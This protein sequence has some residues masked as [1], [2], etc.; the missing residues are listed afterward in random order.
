VKKLILK[1]P[2]NR[3][4]SP[5]TGW[6]RQHWEETFYALMKGIVD[7][8]SPA[9]ARQRIPGPRSH[10][11]LLADELEGFTRSLIM[12]GPWLHSSKTG[13]YSWQGAKVD[14]ASFYRKGILAGTDPKHPEYWGDIVD[15]AQHL[16]EMAALAWGLYLSKDLIWD[17][18]S[19]AEKKQVGGY[20]FQCT[21][22]KYHHN[23]WMLFN[24]V[25]N[26]VLKKLGMPF[27]QEQI[28]ANLLACDNM[29]IGEGWYRDGKINRIDYYNPWG[30]LYYYL[31][32]VILDGES[33]PDIAE[34]HRERTRQFTRQ[35]RYFYAGDGSVPCFGRSMIYRFGFL[36]PVALG[37]HLGCLDIPAGEVKTLCN[38]VMKFFFSNEILTEQNHLS[39]GFL[40]PNAEILEHYSC[41]GSPYW[42][43]KAY[44]LLMI[45][46]DDPFWKVKEEKLPIHLE[47]YSVPLRSAG[48]LLTGDKKTGHV[49]LINQKS[50]HDKPEYN[51]KYTK[52]AYSS[53][54]SY[55]SRL[56]YHNFNCDNIL[57]FS[58]DGINF[59]QRWEMTHLHCEKDFAASKYP[60]YD[61]DKDGTIH[62]SILVKD[63]FMINLHQVETKKQALVFQEGGYPLGFDQGD[64]K[65]VSI[66]GAEAA[67]KD[68]K[69]TFIRNLHGYTTQVHALPFADDVN[70][71]NVRYRQSV[72]P[73]LRFE[74]G[75]QEKF[76]LASM[77]CGRVGSD[78]IKK[79]A[80]LV[81]SFKLKGNTAE[82]VFHDDERAFVQIGDIQQVNISLN[83]KKF[84][85]PIVVARVS[86]DGKK[87]F[88][89]ESSGKTQHEGIK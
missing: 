17:K 55:E 30:F 84:S 25:T 43:T 6:T 45:Q 18:F 80:G 76:Y 47:S 56:I 66:K 58:A 10:P 88:V 13:A 24:V 50:Y 51:A 41:G 87:W 9:G 38:G 42:A 8:A 75:T 46:P 48:L 20:L 23:N 89:L 73:V 71:S 14:V 19:P 61:V 21:K 2:A 28:D 35:L 65:T 62:T 39:M 54:F 44:N 57:Q 26:A 74:N 4:L 83:R 60:L 33:K 63:D 3:T 12:S 40:R 82:I 5:I 1:S 16:V 69:L 29:Y 49:Q 70:G 59:R 11:G 32:W 53:I 68:G 52:F 67:Y 36:G 27:S 15:Y 72:V 7:S 86:K 22:V 31:I 81:K 64:A 77:V 34:A 79:L 37:Q 78:S 85:G